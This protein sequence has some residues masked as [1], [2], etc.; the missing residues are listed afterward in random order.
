MSHIC[1]SMGIELATL[2]CQSALEPL[3]G[4]GR[5]IYHFTNKDSNDIKIKCKPLSI[6]INNNQIAL[7]E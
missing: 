2:A 3:P 7:K 5:R 6:I 1:D 4:V